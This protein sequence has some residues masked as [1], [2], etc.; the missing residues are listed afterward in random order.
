MSR[1]TCGKSNI[2]LTKLFFLGKRIENHL[3]AWLP[4]AVFADR[5]FNLQ[6]FHH[7][8]DEASGVLI[9]INSKVN[10]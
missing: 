2:V 3:E 4:A 8:V 1:F 10:V 5:M 6:V 9:F 7:T